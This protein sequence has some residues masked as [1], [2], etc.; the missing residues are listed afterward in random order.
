MPMANNAPKI[1]NRLSTKLFPLILKLYY[2]ISI[3]FKEEKAHNRLI[4]GIF[5]QLDS[6]PCQKV[7]SS[8][9]K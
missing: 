1:K 7:S 9:Y 3:E 8:N 5:R 2:N 4:S 6:N